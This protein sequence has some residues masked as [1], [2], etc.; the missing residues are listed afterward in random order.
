MS[1]MRVS[2]QA[3]V[4]GL[5]GKASASRRP[6]GLSCTPAVPRYMPAELLLTFAGTGSV[7]TPGQADP[8]VQTLLRRAAA[9]LGGGELQLVD[10]PVTPP[11]MEAPL[12]VRLRLSPAGAGGRDR[13]VDAATRLNGRRPELRCGGIALSCA[14]PNWIIASAQPGIVGGPGSAPDGAP[15]GDWRFELPPDATPPSPGADQAH[16]AGRVVVCVLDTSPGWRGL[17]HA[18]RRAI[19][20]DNRLL[21]EVAASGT[22]TD[23]NA[24]S[25]P[26]DIP[27]DLRQNTVA[28]H[29]L[30]V[31]G[32]IHSIAPQAEIQLLHILDDEG[33]GR[34]DLL[35]KALDYCGGLAQ[36]GQRVVVNMSLYL[37]IPPRGAQPA[38]WYGALQ[39]LLP[40]R[41]PLQGAELD[42][43]QDG[44]REHVHRLLQDGVVMV[45]A[46]GNDALMAK[47]HVPARP[48]A[49]YR[50]VIGVVAAARDGAIAAYSNRGDA[51]AMHTCIAT[52]GGQG[53]REGASVV[54]PPGP[55]PRDGVVGL[56]THGAVN[57]G[58]G[59]WPNTTGWAYWSG[60]SFAT[61]IVSALAANVLARERGLRPAEVTDRLVAM[62][63]PQQETDPN[64]GCPYVKVVQHRWSRSA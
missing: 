60:T 10:A 28:D 20:K 4:R 9:L 57:T 17:Q 11:A 40:H 25:P 42:R 63:V 59:P 46:A 29:G 52:Y 51:E 48:P 6:R 45:A 43:L 22:I 30:F 39:R 16:Q 1:M 41:P 8:R 7:A 53:V 27:P 18:A 38:A 33:F 50:G 62:A 31:A 32:I 36:Q 37:M 58:S 26:D 44:V 34:T 55:D 14:M 19:F 12:T 35:L 3:G 47:R 49:D 61:P 54:V 24:F 13:V 15:D 5:T 2:I 64:L 56:Y 23:W 21:H